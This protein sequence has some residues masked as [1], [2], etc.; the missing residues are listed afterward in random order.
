MDPDVQS[1]YEHDELIDITATGRKSGQPHRIEIGFH[2]V[3][4]KLYI[5]GR[6][7]KR[8]WHANL[9]ADP[10]FTFHLKGAVRRDLPARA[11]PVNDDTARR[12]VLAAI[13]TRWGNVDE[14]ESYVENSP[15]VEVTLLT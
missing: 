10:N 14:L 4:G 11:T 3:A 15:L 9:L 2:I 1:A 12:E 8:D 6:P 7:G 13:M 5:S